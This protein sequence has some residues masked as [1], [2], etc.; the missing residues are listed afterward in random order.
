MD[1]NTLIG[2]SLFLLVLIVTVAYAAL[3]VHR[4]IAERADAERRM[5]AALEE[6]HR[7]TAELRARQGAGPSGPAG[8]AGP[9]GPPPGAEG[10]R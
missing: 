9:G 8:P 6:L 1:A 7:L 10:R 2:I 5:G 4:R 3:R